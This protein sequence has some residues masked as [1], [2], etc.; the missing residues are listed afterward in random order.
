MPKLMA[1]NPY[2]S[3]PPEAA[4]ADGITLIGN[5]YTEERYHIYTK[6]DINRFIRT[7]A[8]GLRSAKSALF[9][10]YAIKMLSTDGWL[11]T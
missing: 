10:L 2:I 8:K 11:L 5:S 9:G 3:P 1:P 6:F 7:L 4:T